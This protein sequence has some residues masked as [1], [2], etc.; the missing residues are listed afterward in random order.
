MLTVV[1]LKEEYAKKLIFLHG[2]KLWVRKVV[3]QKM[4]I[5]ETCQGLMKMVEC[6]EDNCLSCPKGEI[7]SGVTHKKVDPNNQSK[8]CNKWGQGKPRP[9]SNK[10]LMGK[11]LPAKKAKRNLFKVKCFNCDNNG[12]M[13]KDY[14]KSP[15]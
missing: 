2:L 14:L 11:E 4:D 3:Y 10:K 6:M 1:P 12:H 13:V 15:W 5:S 7:K 9:Q 8:G